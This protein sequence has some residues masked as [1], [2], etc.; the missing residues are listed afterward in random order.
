M[1]SRQ[2]PHGSESISRSTTSQGDRQ[3]LAQR[4]LHA[5][6]DEHSA[7]AITPPSSLSPD[8]CSVSSDQ[9]N[10]SSIAGRAVPPAETA[11]SVSSQDTDSG[12][13]I[14]PA[15]QRRVAE[16]QS[17]NRRRIEM[18]LKREG[19]A[20]VS[21]LEA[22]A[23]L[24]RLRNQTNQAQRATVTASSAGVFKRTC[25]TDLLFLIDTTSSMTP[26]IEAAKNQVISI[27]EDINTAF[28][29]RAGVRMAVVGY[30]DHDDYDH[31]QF[32]DFTSDA[33]EVCSFL[34]TLVAVGGGDAPEDVLGG[35]QQALHASWKLPTRCIIHIA[36][37]PPHGR[38]LHDLGDKHD[39]F[40][41][42]GS[43]PHGLTHEVILKR[44]IKKKIN[45]ALFRIKFFTDRMAYTFFK[46]Y[47]VHSP[48][49]R[50]HELNE[51]HS[52]A[53]KTVSSSP[54]PSFQ[55][56]AVSGRRAR[57]NLQ[58]QELKL[59]TS[60]DALQ[61][62]VVNFVTTSASRST[63]ISTSGRR[64][65]L[66][67]GKP[68]KALEM[69]DEGRDEG[70][71][72][73]PVPLDIAPP[74][75]DTP[76]WLNEVLDLEAFTTD[77]VAHSSSMLDQ[78]MD[79]DDNIHISTTDLTVHKR[80]RPFAQGAMRVASYA[81]SDAS[82]NRLV[83]KSYRRKGKTLA[84][85]IDDMRCQALCK[86]F[87][88]EFN[89][90]LPIE[91]SLD[92]TVVTC[93][94]PK[95]GTGKTSGDCLSLEPLIEGEYV[96]Y[97]TNAAWVNTDDPYDAMSMAAQAFSH[98]TFERSQ[99]RF[100]VCDLQGVGRVLTDPGIHSRDVNRFRLLDTNLHEDGF[101]FFFASHKCNSVCR[102]LGLRSN[103]EM[104]VSGE[105]DFTE[106]W[107]NQAKVANMMVCCSNKLCSKIIRMTTT[108]ISDE[109]P[110]YR[111]CK[112][113]WNELQRKTKNVC[114][115][116]GPPHQFK[117]SRFFYESQGQIQPRL[118]PDHRD[119]TADS[120]VS[121]SRTIPD[122]RFKAGCTSM[123]CPMSVRGPVRKVGMS[124]QAPRLACPT[125]LEF[126]F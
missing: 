9:T 116:P 101:F 121:A 83:V 18:R 108:K 67:R 49:C 117:L 112:P 59:G 82:S 122:C 98:F 103:G 45:Y 22:E 60:Y 28:F 96:K 42:P 77:V 24:I 70:D 86:A 69:I 91:Y 17:S 12:S 85:L 97:N 114:T 34:D 5:S 102:Q 115:A 80:S 58:F 47:T 92:F 73:S 25:S 56:W 105:Y 68:R 84:H 119:G 13:S 19:E 72:D 36:D 41:E 118:C 126:Y 99:G 124:V 95:S 93:L 43:E 71:E 8:M 81:R 33:S 107:P 79:H 88:L 37:M 109:F 10:P 21:A 32:L 15:E 125:R 106:T 111:W 100:L 30:K 51:H 65:G 44:L 3:A 89:V 87:A 74:Q 16:M 123:N 11:D 76:G 20:V 75:W 55:G 54:R 63:S 110:G 113:C 29:H 104:L 1:T 2:L 7:P 62:L 23:R 39:D 78:M 57:S 6:L 27:M 46:A 38:T 35:L 50:L 120:A 64:V 53:A 40:P 26:Y 48:D 94:Q 31:I 61:H 52:L 66:R 4:M 90:M 14:H